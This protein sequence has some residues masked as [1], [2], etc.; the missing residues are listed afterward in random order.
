MQFALH[1]FTFGQRQQ[2]KNWNVLVPNRSYWRLWWNDREA[3]SVCTADGEVALSSD[4]FVMV[5][6]HTDFSV[7]LRRPTEHVSIHFELAPPFD[8]AVPG[9]YTV[10]AEG[11]I[12]SLLLACRTPESDRRKQILLLTEVVSRASQLLPADVWQEEIADPRIL[13][14]LHA[15]K[16]NLREPLSNDQ[17]AEIAHMAPTAFIRRFKQVVGR[18]PQ[19]YYLGK[20]LDRACLLLETS[21]QTVDTIAEA[22]GFCDRNYFSSVF[23]KHFRISPAAFRQSS[24]PS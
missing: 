12:D 11:L 3:A 10:N 9:I 20:R 16:T 13:R 19:T 21:S 17:L 1:C 7:T 4:R 5:A 23:R 24:H 18:S 22:C 2:K 15:M 14:V 8:S 6:P